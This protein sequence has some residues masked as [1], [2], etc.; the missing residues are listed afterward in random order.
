MFLLRNSQNMGVSLGGT[1]LSE[2][3]QIPTFEWDTPYLEFI[4]SPPNFNSRWEIYIGIEKKLFY[5]KISIFEEVSNIT[6]VYH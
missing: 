6:K 1:L 2:I 3:H 5:E 4:Q